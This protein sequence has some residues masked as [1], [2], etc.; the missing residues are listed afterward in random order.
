MTFLPARGHIALELE[1]VAGTGETLVDA[2]VIHPVFEPVWTPNFEVGERNIIESSF[3]RSKQISGER[4]GTIEFAVE[5]RGSGAD[6]TVTPPTWDNALLA[7]GFKAVDTGAPDRTYSPLSQAIQTA[8]IEY[9]VGGIGTDVRTHRLIGAHGTVRLEA[10]K[11][12]PVML[13]FTFTG[14]YVEPSDASTQFVTPSLGPDP[15]PMLSAAFTFQ[16]I[17]SL[18]VAAVNID[19]GNNVIMRNDVNEATGNSRA[20]ITGRTPTGDIDP[21]AVLNA[22]LNF[23]SQLTT[24]AEGVMTYVLDGG[25]LNK[26][27]VSAPAVQITN[28]SNADRDGLMTNP[29]DLVFNK[30]ADI[31]DDELTILVE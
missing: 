17:G 30:S 9:R 29:L 14:K 5:L 11:G 10:T 6:P 1:A 8:T 18:I 28:L 31:G 3:S 22:T 15:E 7:S 25:A 13:R 26:V 20:I 16:G 21:E 12:Q 27:T 23:F 4:S 19:I 24:N 2:D